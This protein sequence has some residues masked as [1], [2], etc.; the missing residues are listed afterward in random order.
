VPAIVDTKRGFSV[1][2]HA[3][4]K[5]ATRKRVDPPRQVAPTRSPVGDTHAATARQDNRKVAAFKNSAPYRGAV[6]TAYSS[7]PIPQRRQ[8]LAAA[9]L[10]KSREGGTIAQLHNQRA[11]SDERQRKVYG[12]LV[13]ERFGTGHRAQQL[14]HLGLKAD[15]AAVQRYGTHLTRYSTPAQQID[16]LRTLALNK[17][18]KSFGPNLSLLRPND[19][20]LL[21]RNQ[22]DSLNKLLAKAQTAQTLKDRRS[23][24][25]KILGK[26]GGDTK[27]A[28]LFGL[29][30]ISRPGAAIGAANLE[31][32]NTGMGGL[33]SPMSVDLGK[34]AHGL[35][36]GFLHPEKH[37]GDWNK[38][39]ENEGIK[40]K[41]VQDP[42]AFT[43]SVATDPLTYATLGA[44]S[45]AKNAALKAYE[46]GLERGMTEAEAVDAARN[47]WNM[48]PEGQRVS[49]LKVGIRGTP[50]L[51][52]SRGRTAHLETRPFG[53]SVGALSKAAA[54]KAGVSNVRPYGL[55][56]KTIRNN[57]NRVAPGV[58]PEG[59]DKL[60][61]ELA[62]RAS[63]KARAGER[64]ASRHASYR[65]RAYLAA[66]KDWTPAEHQ[67]AMHA[68]ERDEVRTL[69][70]KLR[71]V[72]EQ[73]Q[74]EM[75]H[76]FH[77]RIARGLSQPLVPGSRVGVGARPAA[78]AINPAGTAARLAQDRSFIESLPAGLRT[79]A[80]K[81][82][83]E[84]AAALGIE[85]GAPDAVTKADVKSS[86][87]DLAR[88]RRREIA[89]RR[90]L[91]DLRE[92]LGISQGRAEI[93]SRNVA[94]TGHVGT[95][96]EALKAQ[97]QQ[98]ID[99]GDKLI[100]KGEAATNASPT[101]R[102]YLHKQLT[103]HAAYLNSLVE[104][105]KNLPVEYGGERGA[106]AISKL[107]A[108][109]LIKEG[110]RGTAQDVT[111]YIDQ[112]LAAHEHGYSAGGM[113]VNMA[114]HALGEAGDAAATHAQTL[115]QLTARHA[116]LKAS[117]KAQAKLMRDYQKALAKWEAAP[118]GFYP[119]VPSAE[120]MDDLQRV[121][122]YHA[123]GNVSNKKRILKSRIEDMNPDQ[124]SRFEQRLPHAAA[125]YI[126]QHSRKINLSHLNE[127]IAALGHEIDPQAVGISN[128]AGRKMELFEHAP[129]GL[130]P[131]FDKYGVVDAEAVQKAVDAG[132]RIVEV[133]QRM[134]A[135]VR[136]M[137]RGQRELPGNLPPELAMELARTPEQVNDQSKG[138]LAGY[139]NVQ[140]RLKVLQTS[141]NPAY[142]IVNL[143]GD[144]FN[145]AIG[146]ARLDDFLA[147]KRL[148]K[149]ESALKQADLELDPMSPTGRLHRAN[150]LSRAT[151]DI[152][153]KARGHVETYGNRKLSDLQVVTLGVAHGALR[154]GLTSGELR[155]AS[156]G[157]ATAVEGGAAAGKV[158]ER[159]Q[160]V[161][162]WREDLVRLTTFRSALKRG[163]SP[164]DAAAWANRHHFD[165]A[166]LSPVEQKFFR[167][168]IPFWTFTARNTPLQVRSLAARPGVYATEEKAR[169]QSS[170]SAGLPPD[171]ATHL[172][173]FE[174]AGVPWG[175]PLKMALKDTKLGHIIAPIT[176]YPKL[177]LMD[178]NNIPFPQ[179]TSEGQF[180][181]GSTLQE[182]GLNLLN[183]VTPLA[184]IPF[185]QITGQNLFTG[186]KQQDV[187]QAPSWWD[188][189]GLPS[190]P[191]QDNRTGKMTRG[192]SWRYLEPLQAAPITNMLSRQGTSTLHGQ[193]EAG[194]LKWVGWLAGPRPAI[195]DPRVVKI[196]SMFD[197]VDKLNKEIGVLEHRVKHD[198]GAEWHGKIGRKIDQRTEL[199]HKIY[200][201]SAR[202]G[203]AKPAG[204]PRAKPKHHHYGIGG[205]MSGGF[206][207]G[208]G[209]LG[210]G[211]K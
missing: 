129:T 89:A 139:D 154:T 106:E 11:A 79:T 177:P 121:G 85:H 93:L 100:A 174:Q 82:H 166:D 72:A 74:T 164:D 77:Q 57:L 189:L 48:A 136:S 196:N 120:T 144:S 33:S 112:V 182:A 31:G 137:A 122:T 63:R 113:G 202:T 117:R 49:G 36:E 131:L 208:S 66:T 76:A 108:K 87:K 178:L 61:W 83:F 151:K 30:Q 153:D 32:S 90:M 9:A 68:I 209:T 24:F 46:H 37:M 2:L 210:G 156:R 23:T 92:Q 195:Q 126:L 124:A 41:W 27:S 127:R 114:L 115:D 179:D 4:R 172:R 18:V 169:A 116:S 73:F 118:A 54:R 65:L 69:P 103:D 3:V 94:G 128:L 44:G 168:V 55:A 98:A 67:I 35:K 148:R 8:A 34:F 81:Q 181:P 45:A 40:N 170:D 147:G 111:R 160:N 71:P 16:D 125:Q 5:R 199:L 95:R 47:V 187:V 123:S 162:D 52:L 157:A 15:T 171:F 7:Q 70:S 186:T 29:Q 21:P 158:M 201:L 205:G 180:S 130:H 58:R 50:A 190:T 204:I 102:A 145:A 211:F 138:V 51:L 194:N 64:E 163:M 132:N 191:F 150:P 152:L 1:P 53:G 14:A 25:S 20:A 133:D 62:R 146:G 56:T 203:A 183:R 185:E 175:T 192:I 104:Q 80:L 88:A 12:Y 22:K 167:R 134:A 188:K 165:Y 39:L 197:R 6:R 86:A 99:D 19:P 176:A 42:L 173:E 97:I 142:H 13:R 198:R 91:A 101:V 107:R 26:V 10:H 60:D 38:K 75:R 110:K 141:I 28:A 109:A 200:D 135:A 78:P 155:A 184:K 140:R 207:A 84:N 193:P 161:S 143:I 17:A 149:I 119:R 96:V 105:G 206:R 43:E 59:W 159:L